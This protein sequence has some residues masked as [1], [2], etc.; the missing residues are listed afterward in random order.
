MQ[1]QIIW[2]SEDLCYFHHCVFFNSR[3]WFIYWPVWRNICWTRTIFGTWNWSIVRIY[4]KFWQH[5][6][7]SCIPFIRP[8]P[9][10]PLCKSH[11]SKCFM[12]NLKK[13]KL[14]SI[15]RDI[16][17]NMRLITKIWYDLYISKTWMIRIHFTVVTSYDL[18]ASEFNFLEKSWTKWN[19]S[20]SKTV[21]NGIQD[22]NCS[23][24]NL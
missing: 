3:E 19:S 5:Q 17:R 24:N 7:V 22:W 9:N 23:R 21:Q 15:F 12:R 16:Q 13:N 18:N 6:I 10:V 2:F 4:R 8:A 11:H 14:I 20:H 1:V